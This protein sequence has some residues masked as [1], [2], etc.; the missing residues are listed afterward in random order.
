M[1]SLKRYI[2]FLTVFISETRF[3]MAFRTYSLMALSLMVVMK[4]LKTF[5]TSSSTFCLIRVDLTVRHSHKQFNILTL[6]SIVNSLSLS[7]L[8]K[9]SLSMVRSV[10]FTLRIFSII[11]EVKSKVKS[12]EM[13]PMSFQTTTLPLMSLWGM[14]FQMY[15]ISVH[16]IILLSIMYLRIYADRERICSWALFCMNLQK[17]LFWIKYW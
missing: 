15:Q 14:I 2:S 7:T 3:I 6:Y 10:S 12:L 9:F 16:P 4:P 13:S 17:T 11:L 8:N 5:S 1:N